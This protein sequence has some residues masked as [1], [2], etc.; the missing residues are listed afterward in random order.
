L[1]GN[2]IYNSLKEK[3]T[4]VSSPVFLAKISFI[5]DGKIFIELG[6]DKKY[7]AGCR[8]A[9]ELSAGSYV[10]ASKKGT[11]LDDGNMA[12]DYLR[13]D[14]E[15]L[16]VGLEESGIDDESYLGQQA[17]DLKKQK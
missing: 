9:K 3:V 17:Y 12:D 13:S 6:D 14:E 10:L 11:R 2:I 4:I 5:K 7:Q 15:Y 8:D 16:I 1:I